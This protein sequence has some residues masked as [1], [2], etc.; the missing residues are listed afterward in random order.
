MASALLIVKL[1]IVEQN[2]FLTE[3]IDYD[4]VLGLD[5]WHTQEPELE[6]VQVDQASE[7]VDHDHDHDLW[8]VLMKEPEL[9]VVII[10]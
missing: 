6:L 8:H 7:S 9:E 10:H 3:S 2:V 5:L 4:L 1:F